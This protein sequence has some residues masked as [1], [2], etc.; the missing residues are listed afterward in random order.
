MKLEVNYFIYGVSNLT[1][2]QRRLKVQKYKNGYLIDDSY[3]CSLN[4]VKASLH[5]ASFLK[6]KTLIVTSGIIEQGGEFV[7]TNLLLQDLLKGKDVLFI[8]KSPH[9]LL[10][11]HHFASLI[12]HRSAT[13]AYDLI[14]HLPFDNYLILASGEEIYLH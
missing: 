1:N 11:N 7:K 14:N 8:G 9:P 13:K 4:S 5:V 2:L 10:K 3:N 6:G 12:M